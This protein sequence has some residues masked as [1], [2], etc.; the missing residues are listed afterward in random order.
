M[1][2]S[3]IKNLSLMSFVLLCFSACDLFK[4]DNYESPNAQ[5][6]G[7]ILDSVTGELVET[8]VIVAQS[9]ALRYQEIGWPTGL[10]TRAIMQNGEY[11]DNM[12]FA[13]NYNVTF[14]DCNFYPF[15]IDIVVKKGDNLI[16]YKVTPY[17]RVRD[18]NIRK[19]GN[20]IIATFKL[21]AGKDEV[22]LSAIRLFVS[23]DIYVGQAFTASQVAGVFQNQ[24]FSPAKV[25]NDSE[26][27]TLKIDLTTTASKNYFYKYSLRNFYFRVGAVASV[28]NV[29]TVRYNY[30]PYK[31]IQLGNN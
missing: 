24:S 8:D 10:Q 29:G 27:Y 13:G 9:S 1:I 3:A 15:N 26:T 18:V 21:Q 11:R 14:Y 4:L 31:I 7:G 23:T 28:S 20:E 16:N 5:V 6:H 17:I 19:E 30:A 12:F 2:K 25:I 22:R